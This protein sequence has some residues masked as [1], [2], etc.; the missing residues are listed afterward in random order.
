MDKKI[1][2]RFED[3]REYAC[4]AQAFLGDMSLEDMKK[5]ERTYF[6]VVRAIEVVGEAAAQ[7]GRDALKDYDGVP[8]NNV[9]AMR[10]I[11]IH[12]YSGIDEKTIYE[13]VTD[14][15]PTIIS[16]LNDILGDTK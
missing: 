14:S 1:R 5:D 3:M 2:N 11:L 15:L 9:I 7:I 6:A 10:N 13:T 12:Q 8:W 4:K 16:R